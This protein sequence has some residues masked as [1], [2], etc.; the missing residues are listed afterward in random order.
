MICRVLRCVFDW[1]EAQDEL[2]E[3]MTDLMC[4]LHISDQCFFVVSEVRACEWPRCVQ[5]GC[6]G[7]FKCL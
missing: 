3:S 6:A 2:A 7:V 1:F 4:C 5:P